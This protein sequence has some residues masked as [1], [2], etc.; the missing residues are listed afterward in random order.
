MKP[1]APAFAGERAGKVALASAALRTHF[2]GNT[3]HG[4]RRFVKSL[5]FAAIALA[6]GLTGCMTPVGPVEVT[7]FHVPDTS[8]LAKGS[9]S[10]EPAAGNSADSLEWRSYQAAVARQLVLLG[11]TEAAAGQGAQVAQ[12]RYSRDTYRPERARGPVSVGMSGSTGS[13]GSGIGL[14]IGIDLSGRP[15]EQ[16][17][18]ELGVIIRNRAT[19]EALW[20]G[21]ASFAVSAKSPLSQTALAAPK[22]AEALFKTFPGQSGETVVVP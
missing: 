22:M 3:T 16:S 19:S 9:I 10:V 8:V 20:E 1:E 11:Y 5:K 2:R 13:Y 4:E 7:R 14:G 17:S 15:P 21:R 18:T 12:L 6:A